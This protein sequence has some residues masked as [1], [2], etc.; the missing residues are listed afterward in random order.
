MH[1]GLRGCLTIFGCQFG[2]HLDLFTNILELGGFVDQRLI[3]MAFLSE[4]LLMVRV[5]GGLNILSRS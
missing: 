4:R 2:E 5:E 1:D 3:W